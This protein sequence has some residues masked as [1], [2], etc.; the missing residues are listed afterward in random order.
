MLFSGVKLSMG[1]F[2][3]FWAGSDCCWNANLLQMHEPSCKKIA[4]SLFRDISNL[5]EREPRQCITSNS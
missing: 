1:S 5:E 3:S 4:M 2:V